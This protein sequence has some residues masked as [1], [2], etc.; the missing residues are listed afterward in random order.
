MCYFYCALKLLQE[1]QLD[2][3]Y[4]INFPVICGETFFASDELQTVSTPNWPEH[5]P[6]N[7]D[8]YWIIKSD[9]GKLVEVI[10]YPGKTESEEDFVEAKFYPI[11][12]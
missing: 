7:Q 10:L 3:Q 5:Y 8:C 12:T 2:L 4:F 6:S 9:G 11:S 1:F